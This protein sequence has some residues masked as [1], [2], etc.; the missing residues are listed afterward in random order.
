MRNPFRLPVEKVPDKHQDEFF[1][2]YDGFKCKTDLMKNGILAIDDQFISK[3]DRNS[4]A[5]IN[6]ICIYVTLWVGF[7]HT[8]AIKK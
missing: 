2:S 7:F 3:S 4:S 1:G 8:F 5:C 6:P